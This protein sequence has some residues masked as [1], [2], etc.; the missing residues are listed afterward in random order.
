MKSNS[1][2]AP[3]LFTLI[4]T[5]LL[6]APA[7][8]AAEAEIIPFDEQ[9]WDLSGAQV[10]EHLG[11]QALAGSAV[12][13][14]V[15]FL[16]GVVEFEMALDGSRDYPGLSFR[17]Q[18]PGDYEHFYIR[19]HN[20][21]KPEALQYAPVWGGVSCWQLYH[22]G[23]IAAAE[24]PAGRWVPVRLE[25]MGLDQLAKIDE[26]VFTDPQVNVV[27]SQRRGLTQLRHP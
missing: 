3:A 4:L 6:T 9:H 12:L 11:R 17:R 19:P 8:A 1:S 23:Y 25:I 16:D 22:E 13:K 27:E 15:E 5:I 7:V 18:S 24:I 20:S 14:D 2:L 10:V 21:T 26:A